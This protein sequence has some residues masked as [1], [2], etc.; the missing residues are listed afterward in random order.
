MNN[1]ELRQRFS[2]CA[3]SKEVLEVQDA[4]LNEAHAEKFNQ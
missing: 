4:Y 2:S 1:L 3:S